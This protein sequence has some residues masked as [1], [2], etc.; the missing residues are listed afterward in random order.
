MNITSVRNVRGTDIT[1]RRNMQGTDITSERNVQGQT[2]QA[3]PLPGKSTSVHKTSL[4]YECT[5]V[6]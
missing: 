4:L 3:N 2:L 6:H 1:S 5:L